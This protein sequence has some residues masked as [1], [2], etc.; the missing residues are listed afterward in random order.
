[1][2]H[3]LGAPPSSDG[4]AE[5]TAEIWNAQVD[6]F[7]V[8]GLA[9][10]SPRPGR[11]IS[12][13]RSART[14]AIT[15]RPTRPTT[16]SWASGR[17]SARGATWWPT[18]PRPSTARHPADGLPAQRR[19]GGRSRRRK[20]SG[21]AGARKGGWQLP[22]RAGRRAPGR[23]PAQLG[24]GVRD[25]SLRWGNDVSGWWIDGCYFADADVPLD[26]EPNF[27]SFAAGPEGRQPRRHRRLQPRRQ[28]AGH[29][30]HAVRGLHGRRG[31]PAADARGGRAC[32]GR[33]VERDGHKAQ[34]QILSYLGKTWCRGERPHFP[35]RRS[36]TTSAASAKG[37][38][39]RLTCPSRR[40]A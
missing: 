18:W 4:G 16:A 38:A 17:A 40:A 14:R 26:D 24:G 34:F 1:M 19:P 9:G 5:L 23:V 8:P 39:S 33:W 21:G 25:W 28:G 20:R 12:C 30:P 13:S 6:A 10:R 35:T 3:Y 7:D 29:L 27:A 11:S 31:E 32:P 36:S 37:G 22:R 2:T 15:A